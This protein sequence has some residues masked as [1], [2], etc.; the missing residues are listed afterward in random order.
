[1]IRP[2]TAMDFQRIT[3]IDP[4]ITRILSLYESYGEGFDFVAFWTQESDGRITAEIS[5][6]EDKFSLW[7]TEAS[8]LEEIAAFIRFQGAGSCLY[9]TAFAPDFP[10]D[11]PTVSGQ[12]LEFTG[13]DDN[14]VTELYEPDFKE[15]YALLKA[16]ESP[17]FSV[18]EYLMFLSEMTHRRN[19][20][21]LHTAGNF[22][23]GMLVSSALTVSET[24]TAAI[25][26]AVATH[27]D[28]RRRGYSR[29]LVRVLA[30]RL[31]GEGRRVFVLS[32]SDSHTLFYQKS[33]FKIV[34]DFKESFLA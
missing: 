5:R 1:M 20:G 14:S 7:L 30:T 23:D 12:V 6:F 13:D 2:A 16:C 21:K 19:R 28:F 9:N 27:P 15:L 3:A 18:P 4:F 10:A 26:G 34:A 24:S 8:D 29:K 31:R 25:L 11:L 33:G 32:A 22:A 17:A